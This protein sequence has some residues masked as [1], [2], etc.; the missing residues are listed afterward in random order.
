MKEFYFTQTLTE[1]EHDIVEYEIREYCKD[2]N[3][4]VK[5][6]RKLKPG[7]VPMQRECKIIGAQK[8][9]NIFKKYF[10]EEIEFP[11]IFENYWKSNE[12]KERE[13]FFKKAGWI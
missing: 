9:I 3:L 5:Y 1:N 8:D 11:L 2:H 12:Y 13:D 4:E 10:T 7:H 6:Y